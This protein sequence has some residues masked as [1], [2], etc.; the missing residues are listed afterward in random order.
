VITEGEGQIMTIYFDVSEEASRQCINLTPSKAIALDGNGQPLNVEPESGELCTSPLALPI[1]D[2]KPSQVWQ[3]RWTPLPYLMTIVGQDISRDTFVD[4]NYYPSDAI[5]SFPPIVWSKNYI[6]SPIWVLPGIMTGMKEQT[7]TVSVFTEDEVLEDDFDI[8]PIGFASQPSFVAISPN[9]ASQGDT[10]TATIK[11]RNTT[12]MD[13]SW[14]EVTFIPSD[15]IMTFSPSVKNDTEITFD[16]VIDDDAEVG[17]RSVVVTYDDNGMKSIIEY[18]VFQ[19]L[20][21]GI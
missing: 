11:C 4:L 12:F 15:G 3:S 10:L 2:I 17:D 20:E 1:I 5:F 6:W 19:V 21:Q 9:Q 13:A 7:V 16:I 18:N 14:I 8:L